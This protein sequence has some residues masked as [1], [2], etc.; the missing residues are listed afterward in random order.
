MFANPRHPYTRA[1]LSAELKGDPP[2]PITRAPMVA[3]ATVCVW[4]PIRKKFLRRTVAYVKAVDG[5]SLA[6][7][8]GQTVGVVGEV[9]PGKTTLGLAILRL[10]R[11]G[12][13]A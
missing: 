13:I 9:W 10:I 5:V 7:R 12:P 11:S 8:E 6:V 3:S 1:L 4:F 2:P